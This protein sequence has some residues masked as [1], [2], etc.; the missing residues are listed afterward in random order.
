M[1][2]RNMSLMAQRI[3]TYEMT[4]DQIENKVSGENK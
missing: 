4:E 2:P 3:L 1:A